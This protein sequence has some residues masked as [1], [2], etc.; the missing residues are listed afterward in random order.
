MEPNRA[1]FKK[2]HDFVDQLKQKADYYGLF[3]EFEKFNVTIQY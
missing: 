3:V 2:N 1:C